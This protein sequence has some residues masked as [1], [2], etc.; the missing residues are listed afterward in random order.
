M[1]LAI[2]S[3]RSLGFYDILEKKRPYLC[4][5][6]TDCVFLRIQEEHSSIGTFKNNSKN[7]LF[8]A[9]TSIAVKVIHLLTI[10]LRLFYEFIYK[11]L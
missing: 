2:L 10:T 6:Y 4:Q 7:D 8:I 1:L 3:T 11:V 9:V 5:E